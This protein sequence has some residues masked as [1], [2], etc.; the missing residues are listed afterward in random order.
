MNSQENVQRIAKRNWALSQGQLALMWGLGR[1]VNYVLQQRFLPLAERLATGRTPFQPENF[2][3][4]LQQLLEATFAL[5]QE[6]ARN[7]QKGY[8]PLAVLRP[9]LPWQQGLRF[10]RILRDGWAL[11][12][13]RQNKEHRQFSVAVE[14]EFAR[15]LKDTPAYYRRNFHFQTDGYFSPSSAD[16]YDHQVEILFGGAADPMRRIWIPRLKMLLGE[17]STA[18]ENFLEIGCGTGRLTRFVQ[19]AFPQA[20][21]TATDP[22]DA[23]LQKARRHCAIFPQTQFLRAFGEALPLRSEIYDVVYSSFVFHE[24]PREVRRQVL[25]ES[26]RVL[27]P[28]GYLV[29]LDSIQTGDVPLFD[30]ALERFPVDFHEP[31]FTDYSKDRME[32]WARD[33]NNLT[34]RDQKI[35]L[36]SKACVLQKS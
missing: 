8:Y 29:I 10:G 23:Y 16:L 36:L 33:A 9:E 26:A 5:L 17:T 2:P 31:F 1:S 14:Q 22:S 28:G 32:L 30:W 35:G 4:K 25:L 13:R 20:R 12:K 3:Q 6:D 18:P 24:L 11:A 34:M 15:S 7:I 21:I 19:L 27:K